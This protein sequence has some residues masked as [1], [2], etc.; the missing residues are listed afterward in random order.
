MLYRYMHNIDM[1]SIAWR[2]GGHKTQEDTAR[3]NN[4]PT[5]RT[6]SF[7][8]CHLAG[9]VAETC[10]NEQFSRS[11]I[12]NPFTV[13]FSKLIP[14]NFFSEQSY[15]AL[16]QNVG[17]E[18][19]AELGLG[20][21]GAASATGCTRSFAVPPVRAVSLLWKSYISHIHPKQRTR[22]RQRTTSS[23]TCGQNE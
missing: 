1:T 20:P 22:A 18:T 11:T 12:E 23:F 14:A 17:K 5:T 2:S 9:T 6:L 8:Q 7:W 15:E 4:H 19:P 16:Q 13:F 3:R 10:W 21:H